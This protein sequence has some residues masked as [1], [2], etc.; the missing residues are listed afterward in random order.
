MTPARRYD[1]ERDYQER[2]HRTVTQ[3]Q[4]RWPGVSSSP[5]LAAWFCE[6]CVKT[7]C[8]TAKPTTAD[9]DTIAAD[10]QRHRAEMHGG[11]S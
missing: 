2:E 6:D 11:E 10:Y 7:G 5:G 8:H 9:M 1:I 3:H 4:E